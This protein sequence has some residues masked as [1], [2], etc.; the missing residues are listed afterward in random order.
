MIKFEVRN[1]T[2]ADCGKYRCHA[3]NVYGYDNSI[4]ELNFESKNVASITNRNFSRPM[5]FNLVDQGVELSMEMITTF[6]AMLATCALITFSYLMSGGGN[7]SVP[8]DDDNLRTITEYVFKCNP[9]MNPN[10]IP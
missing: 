8:C 4:A 7:S 1:V 6:R 5:R 3:S 2:E 10:D 9:L